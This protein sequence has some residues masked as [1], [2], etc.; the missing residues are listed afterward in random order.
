MSDYLGQKKTIHLAYDVNM[1]IQVT[2]LHPDGSEEELSTMELK[3][4]DKIMEKEVMQKETTTRPKLSL[5]FELS[6]S[7][8]FQLLSAKVS[9]DETVLEEI[10]KEK[11]EE[12]KK[13][14]NEEESSDEAKEGDETADDSEEKTDGDSEE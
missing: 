9:A 8:F 10:V 2:A 6:R 14:D 12:D 3:D 13:E 1:L 5:S 11:K 4:I 7:H